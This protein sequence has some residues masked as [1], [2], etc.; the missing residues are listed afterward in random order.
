MDF[1][2]VLKRHRITKLSIE[3]RRS[4]VAKVPELR[5]KN[6]LI[7]SDECKV[8][9]VDPE[10]ALPA[11]RA[12]WQAHPFCRKRNH[13][14]HEERPNNNLPI[15]YLYRYK[16]R[17]GKIRTTI[18]CSRCIA[19]SSA[20]HRLTTEQSK[21]RATLPE[22]LKNLSEADIEERRQLVYRRTGLMPEW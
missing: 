11:E 18:H 13:S 19:E 16:D 14:L 12:L 5:K 2:E 9:V 15:G 1:D 21:I 10:E 6:S 3:D 8:G 4:S 7:V 17:H 22:G 20:R